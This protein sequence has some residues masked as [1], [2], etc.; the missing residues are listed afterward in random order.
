MRII[1][2]IRSDKLFI[3]PLDDIKTQCFIK[4]KSRIKD[5]CM[6][7]IVNMKT[8][9]VRN[10]TYYILRGKRLGDFQSRRCTK[11]QY[12]QN[13]LPKTLQVCIYRTKFS[14]K[15]KKKKMLT[16]KQKKTNEHHCKTERP[17]TPFR[18][19]RKDKR[20]PPVSIQKTIIIE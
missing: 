20:K 11:V 5:V 2:I 6:H 13:L 12:R 10:H 7:R 14:G 9:Y 3:I 19:S 1:I 15:K 4:I 17:Q 16:E 18:I 8:N